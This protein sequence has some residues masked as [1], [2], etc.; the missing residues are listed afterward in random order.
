MLQQLDEGLQPLS[1]VGIEVEPLVAHE[2]LARAEPEPILA[3]VTLDNRRRR[4]TL[5]ADGLAQRAASVIADVAATPV[6]ELEHAQD[7]EADAEA[8]LHRL[9]D[10]FGAGHSLLDQARR[11][12]HRQ[13]LDAWHDV[14]WARGAN[15][16]HFADA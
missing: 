8:V 4:V 1:P 2:P 3:H 10:V 13:R 11:L 14:A 6:D 12:V 16:G 5:A 9:V 7:S 15:D